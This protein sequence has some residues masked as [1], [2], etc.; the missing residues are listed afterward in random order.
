MLFAALGL[1][2]GVL[3][4]AEWRIAPTG[5]NAA[6]V[7]AL[8]RCC[9]PASRPPRLY[10]GRSPRRGQRGARPALRHLDLHLL[11]RRLRAGP[12]RPDAMRSARLLYWAAAAAALFA[13][14]DF[15]FQFPAPAGYGP[16]FVW[17][18]SGV[19][20][21]AQGL[22]YEAS[23]LG[24]FCAF[25]LVMIAV[26]FTRPRDESPVSRK[27]LAAG[28]AVFFAALVLSYSRASLVNVGGGAR[29]AGV[30]QPQARAPGPR[31]RCWRPPARCSPGGSSRASPQMYWLRLSF[32]A[33]FLFT[34]TEGVLSGR[35]ASWQTLA[36][37]IAAHPWQAMFG[38]GYKTL[39]YTNYL[40]TPG[41]GRQHVPQPAGGDRRGRHGRAG[42]AQRRHPARRRAQCAA[43]VLRHVD[44]VLLGRP[45]GTDWR[46]AT[47]SP[48][49]A[50]CRSTFGFWRWPF[51]YE[52]AAA[53][54]VQRSRRRPAEPAGTAAGHTRRGLARA[55]RACPG[56]G[57]LFERVRA[58]GFEAER[59]ACGPYESGRKSRGGC[60]AASSRAR[61][62]W[63]GRSAAW[64]SAL[65]ADLVYLNGPRLLPAAA[66]A[67]LGLPG[68]VS[69]PQLSGS[70]S[71]ARH[72][73]SG[74][75]SDAW[76]RGWLASASSWPRRGA[77]SCGPERVS[78]I[79]NGVA[80][81][82][83]A[84]AALARRTAP[85]RAASAA[86]RRK[87]DSANSSP[88]PHASTRRCR[89]PL[90]D[91]RRAAVRRPRGRALRSAGARRR[92][93]AAGGVRR[94]GGRYLCLPGATRSAAGALGRP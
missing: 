38:I 39:P 91:L 47:C 81:P 82:P 55:R 15:Y 65:D 16:Q 13:C 8:R 80:G 14:V 49:G 66:L 68:A 26:A 88:P 40:G 17:L 23:T 94:M 93:R 62:D 56:D 32:S 9:W 3:W 50:S 87:R 4:L 54:P 48:T 85:R 75:R 53:G 27:A 22:F 60:S 29:R 76:T 45:D 25:F 7:H 11:L 1:F 34:R 21:R 10:S 2:A 33:E 90:H 5:L 59:I 83:R 58:L 69:L 20:R 24:N 89:M 61:R 28:G 41:G 71:G 19:Y 67:G 72:G 31:R 64:R 74:L 36:G 73:G 79:Y 77:R 57:A 70:G 44:A 12:R 43:L 46:P 84:A 42:V 86:S 52:A 35:V 18:D 51:A 78:V 37:W 63:R 92:R 6:F 30:V